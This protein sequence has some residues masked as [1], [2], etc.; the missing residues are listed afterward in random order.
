MN[1]AIPSTMHDVSNP[2]FVSS[3]DV[4]FSSQDPCTYAPRLQQP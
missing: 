3:G 2:S 1:M 4:V